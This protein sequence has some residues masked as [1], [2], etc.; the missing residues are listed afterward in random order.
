MREKQKMTKFLIETIEKYYYFRKKHRKISLYL[1][2]LNNDIFNK[3]IKKN[4]C[5][6]LKK[7]LI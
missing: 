3:A 1:L 5:N 2:L 7:Y 4:H 6:L